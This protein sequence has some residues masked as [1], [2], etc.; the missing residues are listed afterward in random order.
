MP[1]RTDMRVTYHYVPL[2]LSLLLHYYCCYY[3]YRM[4]LCHSYILIYQLS[5]SKI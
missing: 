3:Y 2:L 1:T 5:S 4:V